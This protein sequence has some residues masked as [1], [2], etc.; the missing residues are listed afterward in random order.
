M[1]ST[2]HLGRVPLV[3]ILLAQ[4]LKELEAYD[5]EGIFRLAAEVN[6]KQKYLDLLDKGCYDTIDTMNDGYL[7]AEVMKRLF[8]LMEEPFIPYSI[9][10]SLVKQE[11][12]TEEDCRRV[13]EQLSEERRATMQFIMNLT[14]AYRLHPKN[15]M[16][17][18]GF[19]VCWGPSLMR[20]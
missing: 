7:V 12:F 2:Q 1:Q 3:F 6:E 4:R 20:S 17:L 9:Y 19:A 11:S 5:L 8:Y 15:C 14:A 16:S 18:D 10:Q 13:L